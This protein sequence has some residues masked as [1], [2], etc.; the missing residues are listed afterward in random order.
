MVVTYQRSYAGQVV[1]AVGGVAGSFRAIIVREWVGSARLQVD[2]PQLGFAHLPPALKNRASIAVA[3]RDSPAVKCNPAVG[4]ANGAKAEERLLEPLHDMSSAWEILGE[5][6]EAEF[7]RGGGCLAFPRRSTD[8]YGGD[9]GG[10]R[11]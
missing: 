1:R 9:H 3:N 7:R 10:Q 8:Y 11:Q 2:A 6:G 5:V 4:V